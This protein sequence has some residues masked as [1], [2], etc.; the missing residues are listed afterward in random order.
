MSPAQARPKPPAS[1]Q[2]ANGSAP[3]RMVTQL[4]YIDKDHVVAGLLAIFFGVLGLHKFYLGYYKA[5]FTTMAVSVVGGILTLGLAT[6]VMLVLSLVEG[7]IYLA[8]SQTD[9]T[10]IYVKSARDWF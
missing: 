5:G 10:R 2:Q 1:Y 6:G 9:F 7:F 3:L 8:M 4:D